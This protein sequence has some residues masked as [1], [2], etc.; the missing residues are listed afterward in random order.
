M[1]NEHGFTQGKT[2]PQAY[3]QRELGIF[4]V[5]HG[6]DFISESTAAGSDAMDKIM[7]NSLRPRSSAA[8][9]LELRLK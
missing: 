2:C 7:P 8:S 9:V 5:V 4:V 6:D 1:V 3:E